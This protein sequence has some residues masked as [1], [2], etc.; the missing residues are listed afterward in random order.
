MAIG[1]LLASAAASS[2]GGVTGGGP[3]QADA[4]TKFG[5][6]YLTGGGFTKG[7]V[8]VGATVP[9]VNWVAVSAVAA[10]AMVM[11]AFSRRR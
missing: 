9:P 6:A 2:L 10:V 8:T 11:L 3:A 5:N 7:G 1:A 4:P